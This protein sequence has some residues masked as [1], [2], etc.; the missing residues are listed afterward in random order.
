MHIDY[1]SRINK[2]SRSF[3]FSQTTLGSTVVLNVD[4][5]SHSGSPLVLN[6]VRVVHWVRCTHVDL[7]DQRANFLI[8][9]TP[10]ETLACRI[11]YYRSNVQMHKQL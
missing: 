4:L 5:W 9:F 8:L 11:L 1:N 3:S 10:M 2:T 6:S 7:C